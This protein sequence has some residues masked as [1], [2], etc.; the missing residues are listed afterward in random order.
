MEQL[1]SRAL[2]LGNHAVL[3][4]KEKSLSKAPVT[5]NSIDLCKFSELLSFCNQPLV[6][7]EVDK[8]V[9]NLCSTLYK[10]ACMNKV[11]TDTDV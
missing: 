2:L 1:K 8:S 11:C 10:C 5:G 9:T 7:D 6:N 3:M 4:T